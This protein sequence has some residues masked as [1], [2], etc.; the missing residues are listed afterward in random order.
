MGSQVRLGSIFDG[1]FWPTQSR[2]VL[3]PHRRPGGRATSRPEQD[4]PLFL[5]V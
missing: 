2:R 3:A 4:V 1:Q 5:A